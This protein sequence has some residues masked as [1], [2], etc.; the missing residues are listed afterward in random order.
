MNYPTETR[1]GAKALAAA[2]LTF[3]AADG[4]YAAGRAGNRIQGGIAGPAHAETA[5]IFEQRGIVGAFGARR[6]I[7]D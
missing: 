6:G 7:S 1:Y 2:G 4:T 5:G 3:L